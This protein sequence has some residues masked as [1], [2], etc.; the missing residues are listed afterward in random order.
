M[1]NEHVFLFLDN[2][3]TLESVVFSL[4]KYYQQENGRQ[5]PGD[6]T[7]S[8][9]YGCSIAPA[10]DRQIVDEH[11]QTW[12][13]GTAELN[14]SLQHWTNKGFKTRKELGIVDTD[15]NLTH[16]QLV[17]SIRRQLIELYFKKK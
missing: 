16:D 13:K 15:E 12:D 11:Y 10:F 7:L 9:T 17:E 4:H 6:S 14:N 3:E 5:I 2:P 1:K 8:V